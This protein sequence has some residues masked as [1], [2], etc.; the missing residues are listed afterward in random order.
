F[1]PGELAAIGIKAVEA[2]LGLA[3]EGEE[4]Q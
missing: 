2:E 1:S 4:N 3:P